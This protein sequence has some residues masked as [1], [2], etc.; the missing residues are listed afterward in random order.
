MVSKKAHHFRTLDWVR[1][2]GNR[3][4]LRV[5][6]WLTKITCLGVLGP[7]R[8]LYTRISSRAEPERKE[9]RT[10]EDMMIQG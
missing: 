5:K 2:S 8:G 1:R 4:R 7:A 10:A 3:I 9:R 6:K